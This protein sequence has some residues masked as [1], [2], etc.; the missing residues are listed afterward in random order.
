MLDNFVSIFMT[1][2]IPKSNKTGYFKRLSNCVLMLTKRILPLL[3]WCYALALL[4]SVDPLVNFPDLGWH[5]RA[6]EMISE[7]GQLPEK[8]WFTFTVP[9]HTWVNHEWLQSLIL[10]KVWHNFELPGVKLL[11]AILGILFI[12][13]TFKVFLDKKCAPF[14]V[15]L[16]ALPFCAVLL[17]TRLLRPQLITAIGFALTLALLLQYR[18][19]KSAKLLVWLPVLF[20]IWANLHAGF[21]SGFLLIAIFLGVEATNALLKRSKIETLRTLASQ[22]TLTRNEFAN[23]IIASVVASVC[24]LLNPYGI[25][26]YDEILRTVSDS[27]PSI[28]VLEWLPTSISSS[29]GEAFF[30][31]AACIV[32]FYALR[33]KTPDLLFLALNLIF[34]LFGLTATRHST[35]FVILAIV[36]IAPKLGLLSETV[37]KE[38]KLIFGLVTL[39]LIPALLLS[40][41]PNVASDTK[42]V[43][44]YEQIYPVKALETLNGIDPRRHVLHA[45]HWGSYL[46]L[47]DRNFKT[48][49]DGRMTQWRFEGGEFEDKSFL[50]MFDDT[51]MLHSGWQETLKQFDIDTVMLPP[52]EALI[53]ALRLMPNEWRNI[54]EDKV[55]V[56]MQK[57]SM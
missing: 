7:L 41:R 2:A 45:F 49:I 8:A 22:N 29:S 6:G 32:M 18:E 46:L 36:Q 25:A 10:Y 54:Y 17:A 14:L 23:L 55:V 56:V 39:V 37:E 42:I 30:T 3:L 28:T 31:A 13:V 48:F 52:S 44:R 15:A 43:S 34:F 21:P 19:K 11:W 35:F 1:T 24:T 33:K 51:R 16:L 40:F 53:S 38:S 5:I 20:W 26:V 9:D 12:A 50:K 27:Y 4:Y 47:R 57:R